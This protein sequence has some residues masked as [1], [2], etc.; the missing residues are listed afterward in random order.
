MVDVNFVHK[1][2]RILS[3]LLFFI[4]RFSWC[5]RPIPVGYYSRDDV[6]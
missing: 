2:I 5:D 3:I 1:N 6:P 4:Q